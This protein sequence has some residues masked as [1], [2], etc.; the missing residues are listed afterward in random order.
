M[1]NLSDL[2]LCW[3]DPDV[4]L[5]QVD[6]PLLG[7]GLKAQRTLAVVPWVSNTSLKQ[8]FSSQYQPINPHFYP[9]PLPFLHS[10]TWTVCTVAT[11]SSSSLEWPLFMRLRF[12]GTVSR[13]CLCFQMDFSL[14][15][16]IRFCNLLQIRDESN[17]ALSETE[18]NH[19]EEICCPGQR[20][21]KLNTDEKKCN[22]NT[23]V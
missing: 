18:L 16:L 21:V 8:R 4:K 9:H 5:C 14:L 10:R 11:V 3:V 19:A 1:I 7:R 22:D 2:D 15:L 20:W 6:N 23:N 17:W 13:D 12:K